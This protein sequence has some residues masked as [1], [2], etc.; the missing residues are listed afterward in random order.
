MVTV[1]TADRAVTA[2]EIINFQR[3][4]VMKSKYFFA[5][6]V[7]F[8]GGIVGAYIVHLSNEKQKMTI[9]A[10]SIEV[11]NR[12]MSLSLMFLDKAKLV[13]KIED[14]NLYRCQFAAYYLSLNRTFEL[15]EESKLPWQNT[16]YLEPMNN[17]KGIVLSEFQEA[18]I[19]TFYNNVCYELILELAEKA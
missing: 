2:Q 13:D 8:L 17:Y 12:Q 19:Q 6:L 9:S 15:I 1:W 4:F 14:I 3:R 18:D 7:F 5:L 11:L 10:M 16:H